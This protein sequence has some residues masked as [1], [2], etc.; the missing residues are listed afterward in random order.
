MSIKQT[1]HSLA[2]PSIKPLSHRRKKISL[3]DF[4]VLPLP[5]MTLDLRFPARIT[6]NKYLENKYLT[7]PITTHNFH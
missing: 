3:P 6:I 7:L 2:S 4:A 1:N 5:P